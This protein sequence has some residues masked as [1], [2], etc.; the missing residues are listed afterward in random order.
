MWFPQGLGFPMSLLG[1]AAQVP[2]QKQLSTDP[3]TSTSLSAMAKPDDFSFKQGPDV[4]SPHDLIQLA[5]PGTGI[6]NLAGDLALV[7][8]SKYSPE[9][10]KYVTAARLYHNASLVEHQR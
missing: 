7:H 3:I 8:V 5:R 9:E 4:F 2:L 10:K 6:A 1:L